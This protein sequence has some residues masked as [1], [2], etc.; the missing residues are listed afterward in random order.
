[1]AL[2]D[3]VE[4]L[5]EQIS[6]D[7]KTI[8][9][10]ITNVLILVGAWYTFR[11]TVRFGA[12]AVDC[13]KCCG[14]AMKRR[15]FVREYGRWAIVTGCTKGIGKAFVHKL[16]SKGLNIILMSRNI[17]DLE[18]EAR[19]IE[20]LYGV[21]TLVVQQDFSNFNLE[22]FK[23]TQEHLDQLEIGILINNVGVHHGPT[24]F[25]ELTQKQTRAM[26]DVNMASTVSLTHAVI[27]GMIRRRKGL[28]VNMSST[29][30]LLHSPLNALYSA[31]KNFMDHFSNSLSYELA[32]H[33][34][35]VQSLVPM[36]IAT[37]MVSYSPTI[38]RFSLFTPSPETYVEHSMQTF[39]HYKTNCGYFPH[40][41]QRYMI[42]LP[43]RWFSVG[44]LHL[45]HKYLRKEA[46]AQLKKAD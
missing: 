32:P 39:G 14:R 33:G 29:A 28:I 36:Y 26:I 8:E 17:D 27:P 9:A 38:Q 5:L 23:T 30:G 41:I 1:M 13:L 15:N 31:T 3:S 12:F 4:M 40:T 18:K 37:G 21:H 25:H 20:N 11:I 35:H 19:F 2:V 10:N 46:I 24:S 6:A 22:S 7:V 16:A 42:M 43:P 45:L 34:V 44:V